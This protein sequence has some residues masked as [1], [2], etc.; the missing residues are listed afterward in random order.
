M[1]RDIRFPA[2]FISACHGLLTDVA[3]PKEFDFSPTNGLHN[4]GSVSGLHIH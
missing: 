2:H 1:Q 4:D 3:W